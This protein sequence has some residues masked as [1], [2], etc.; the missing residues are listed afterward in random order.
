[1]SSVSTAELISTVEVAP[2]LAERLGR[3]FEFDGALF[4]APGSE[5]TEVVVGNRLLTASCVRLLGTRSLAGPYVL[6]ITAR[7]ISVF[8][9]V[10]W[11][12]S[13]SFSGGSPW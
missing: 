5:E 13:F 2:L 4:G 12:V 10:K 11:G 6:S 8:S 9:G 1:M 7:L 3:G